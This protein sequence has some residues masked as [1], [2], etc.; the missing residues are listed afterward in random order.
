MATPLMMGGH[1]RTAGPFG[2]SNPKLDCESFADSSPTPA[3][4][5]PTP[6]LALP[7]SLRFPRFDPEPTGTVRNVIAK[8]AEQ[9]GATRRMFQDGP[10]TG[11]GIVQEGRASQ[12]DRIRFRLR[13]WIYRFSGR[14][15]GSR[16]L[17]RCRE[18]VINWCLISDS[19]RRTGPL[20]PQSRKSRLSIEI[21]SP[22]FS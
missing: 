16:M 4:I 19:N 10:L 12:G 21:G 11:R 20:A 2:V 3:T 17:Q 13:G 18:V 8:R 7:F 14:A 15:G 1:A 5:R 22:Q 9:P 6:R